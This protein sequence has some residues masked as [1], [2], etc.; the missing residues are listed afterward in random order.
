MSSNEVSCTE[1]DN[2][3]FRGS[4]ELPPSYD[5]LAAH[6]GPNSRFGRWRGWIEKR[7]AERYADLTPDQLRRRRARGWG[8]DSGPQPT[9]PISSKG[10]APTTIPAPSTLL[11]APPLHIQTSNLS[12]ETDGSTLVPTT[13]TSMAPLPFGTGKLSPSQL[14][15]CQFGSRFL[16][17][18]TSQIRC[19]LPLMGDRYL[20][21]G[22]D[23]GLSVLDMF[24]NEWGES[25]GLINKGP[26]EAVARQIWVGESVQQM[27]LLEEEHTGDGT[28]TGVV[29]ALVGPEPGESGALRMYNLAGLINLVKW[30]ISTKGAAPLDLYKKN[31]NGNPHAPHTPPKKHRPQNSITR[32]LMHLMEQPSTGPPTSGLD[33]QTLAQKPL[34]LISESPTFRKR[35]PSPAAPTIARSDSSDSSWEILD[36]EGHPQRWASDFVPLATPGSRL[37]GLNVLSY[38]LWCDEHRKGKGGQLLAVATKNNILLYETPKGERAFRFVKEFYTPLQPRGVNFFH[39]NVV[40]PQEYS[41]GHKRSDSTATIRPNGHKRNNSGPPSLLHDYGTHLSLF[42]VFDKKAGWIRIADSAVG[43]MEISDDFNEVSSSSSHTLVKDTINSPTN[44]VRRIRNSFIELQSPN[45]WGP[46]IT[47]CNLPFEPGISLLPSQVHLVTRGRQ[48]QVVP[49]PLPAN[50]SFTPL[51]NVWWRTAPSYVLGRLYSSGG[52]CDTPPFLQ[53]VALGDD[54]IEVQEV[55][56]YHLTQ[57]KGKGKA[58]VMDPLR[59]RED[60]GGPVGFLCGGGHWNNYEEM[61]ARNGLRSSS[62]SSIL[63]LDSSNSGGTFD[64]DEKIAKL[65]RQEGVYGWW[66]KDFQDWRIFW[67]GG[68]SIDDDDDDE[69]DAAS[70]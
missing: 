46:P 9:A 11:A 30:A 5:E 49:C 53:I 45:K 64:T 32:S 34:P 20:L 42:V 4:N 44:T 66:C 23:E 16:P 15:I 54:G 60:L 62:S 14:R 28:P 8:L 25:G 2:V 58:R 63:S 17:H 24:P 48:T 39:Q 52:D 56:L 37:V 19:L 70:I 1:Q 65:K 50:F 26:S 3:A 7:A 35:S 67:M 41:R 57:G 33:P 69:S 59:A 18:A 61:C 43:E 47:K 22:H 36:F 27:T 38:A 12:L 10:V 51:W 29:L 21:I 6:N 31:H 55:A 68:T 13:T 40:M